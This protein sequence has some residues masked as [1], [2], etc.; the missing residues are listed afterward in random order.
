MIYLIDDKT[1]SIDGA[2]EGF[3]ALTG[4]QLSRRAGKMGVVYP[5]PGRKA[6]VVIGGGSGHEPLFI[7]L[8]GPGMAD[9]AALGYIFTA[10]SPGTIEDVV[11]AIEPSEGVIF[12]Y[13]NYSGDGLN[14]DLAI[15]L[16]EDYPGRIET[17]R[18]CDDVAS[19]APEA[20]SL[21]RGIAGGLFVIKCTSAA[22]DRGLPYSEIYRIG[23][24]ANQQVRSIGV[25][26]KAA[27]SVSTGQPMFALPAGEL[28]IGMGIH[29]E[30]GVRRG[31]FESLETLVDQMV[32]ML[33]DDFTATDDR[34]QELAVVVNGLGSTT[35]LELLNVVTQVKIAFRNRACTVAYITA[36]QFVSA[37]DMGGFS[38]S[39]MNMDH[40]LKSLWFDPARAYGFQI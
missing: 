26:T 40:E 30:M 13:G 33:M 36:G 4:Q 2:I 38:I 5:N 8:V 32:T 17:I 16:L 15:E 34:L 28:E 10:P 31:R 21:R 12:V 29:G 22:A 27:T 24:K 19:A 11:N 37:L 25:A 20:M 7:G 23:N 9:G 35:M 14:F 18:V 6:H 39:V 1:L 3:L